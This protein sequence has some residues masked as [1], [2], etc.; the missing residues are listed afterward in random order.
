MS[1][2]REGLI[3]LDKENL[4]FFFETKRPPQVQRDDHIWNYLFQARIKMASQLLISHITR[5]MTDIPMFNSHSSI[6]ISPSHQPMG[7]MLL[8]LWLPQDCNYRKKKGH[9]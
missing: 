2:F 8:D 4:S 3:Y 6:A 7:C 9:L 1:S 5:V